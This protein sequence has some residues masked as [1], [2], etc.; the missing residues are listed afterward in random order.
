MYQKPDRIARY[1][2]NPTIAFFTGRLGVSLRGSRVLAVRGRKS[3][4]LRTVP[5]NLL[6]FEDERYLV[7]PRGDTHW[8]RNLRAAGEGEL[9][10]GR[11][12]EH[13]RVEE[14]DGEARVPIIRAYLQRWAPETKSHFGVT[15]PDA[16]DDELRRI[17]PE[18]PVFRPLP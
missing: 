14:V 12:S 13:F 5:V 8:A 11:K 3:G 18:H 17:A 4:E 1:L 2:L 9:R 16:P 7:A 6:T 15:G 10:L